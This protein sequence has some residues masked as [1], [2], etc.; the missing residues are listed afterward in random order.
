M[1]KKGIG[2]INISFRSTILIVF[3]CLL[4][5]LILLF[6]SLSNIFIRNISTNFAIHI[7][8]SE[9]PLAIQFNTQN[10]TYLSDD[11]SI[12][13]EVLNLLGINKN[14]LVNT[15]NKEIKLK[16]ND[17][18]KLVWESVSPYT[19]IADSISKEEIAA[20]ENNKSDTL[21][22]GIDAGNNLPNINKNAYDSGLRLK[23][24][25]KTPRVLIYNTHTCESYPPGPNNTLDQKINIASVGDELVKELENNYNIYTI[26]DK[27]IHD[28]YGYID[29]YKRSGDT[30]S[31]YLKQYG[32]F[33]LIIDMHRDSITSKKVV[34]SKINN[35]NTA[36]I[37]FVVTKS[38]PHF[39]KNMAV[40]TSLS[41][42]SNSLF[43]GFCRDPFFYNKGSYFFN[44]D[45]SNNAVL[46]EV[47]SIANT[48]TEAKASAKY[49]ARIFAEYLH[50]KYTSR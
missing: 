40:A 4:F 6:R 38:N 27:T 18:N 36:N 5:I 41:T 28:I 8:N 33:D 29:S 45:K 20:N 26:H 7:C 25:G 44:Q 11:I 21:S 10:N 30:L 16:F 43:P 23:E 46:I 49:L 9:F 32:D 2:S 13:E 22:Q 15:L 1:N 19:L 47:G 31:K 42:I 35:E 50:K 14:N 34:T 12:K 24:L 48:T 17:N 39:D 3:I 37:R